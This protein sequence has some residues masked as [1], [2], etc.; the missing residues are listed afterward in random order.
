MPLYEYTHADG[1]R[2]ERLASVAERDNWPNR[3]T[4]PA[5][6]AVMRGLLDPSGA[7]AAVPRA[8][9]RVEE[10]IGADRL[11]HESG[12]TSGQLKRAWANELKAAY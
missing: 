1:S 10:Q 5:R 9:R 3:V 11:A 6:V 12:F 4:V 7:A 8:L 2:S